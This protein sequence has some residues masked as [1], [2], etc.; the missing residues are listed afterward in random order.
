MTCADCKQWLHHVDG[1]LAWRPVEKGGQKFRRPLGTLPPCG[2]C[3]KIPEG[4]APIPESAIELSQKNLRAY[5]HGEE[6][7]ATG[8]W[9]DDPIIRRN[10]AILMRVREFC[11]TFRRDRTTLLASLAARSSVKG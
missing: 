6:C 2:S 8:V 10:A 4:A 5:W 9:P 3:P 11:E 1:P 7:R